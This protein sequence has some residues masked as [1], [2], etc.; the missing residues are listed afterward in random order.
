VKNSEALKAL[1]E[2]GNKRLKE[3]ESLINGM[4]NKSLESSKNVLNSNVKAE[5]SKMRSDMQNSQK[6]YVMTVSTLIFGTIG[7]LFGGGMIGALSL[8]LLTPPNDWQVPKEWQ[9]EQDGK[10]YLI[11][12]KS[13]FQTIDDYRYILIK[14]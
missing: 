6:G 4:L 7:M 10:K 8:Y 3:Q 11:A 12:P 2:L 9:R 1:D 14:G 13:Q 5:L